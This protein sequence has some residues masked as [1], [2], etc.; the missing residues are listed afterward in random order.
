MMSIE[1]CIEKYPDVK[2][3]PDY[4]CMNCQENR[5]NICESAQLPYIPICIAGCLK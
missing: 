4:E 1:E 3:V 5:A 2:D